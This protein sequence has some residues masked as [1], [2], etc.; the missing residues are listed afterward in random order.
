MSLPLLLVIVLAICICKSQTG[1]PEGSKFF[2]SITQKFIKSPRPKSP[3]TMEKLEHD[4]AI[5]MPRISH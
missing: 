2:E 1:A 3:D 5:I 4:M